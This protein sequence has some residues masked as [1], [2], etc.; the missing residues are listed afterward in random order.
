[1]L[2]LI[3]S[4]TAARMDWLAFELI[5]VIQAGRT[6][7]ETP[8]RLAATRQKIREDDQ[9]KAT[10]EPKLVSQEPQPIEGDDQ[11]D[12]AAKYVAERL[13]ATLEYLKQSIANLDAIAG[14][15]LNDPAAMSEDADEPL[16]ALADGEVQRNA[17][18]AQ[19][20][21]A[22]AALPQ[23]RHSLEAWSAQARGQAQT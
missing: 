6:P 21:A 18:R 8:G 23:L 15:D 9:P 20:E 16:V 10:G 3:E 5:E 7:T 12:W 13:T 11:I 17:G 4:L 2:D 1:M 22:I 14:R 19:V